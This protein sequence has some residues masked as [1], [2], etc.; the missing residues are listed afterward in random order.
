VVRYGSKSGQ[1]Q[2]MLEDIGLCAQDLLTILGSKY[3][4]DNLNKNKIF[5]LMMNGTLS[6]ENI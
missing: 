3:I 5:T 1:D 4:Y 6:S 2:D